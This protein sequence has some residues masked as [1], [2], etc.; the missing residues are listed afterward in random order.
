MP[1]V[2]QTSSPSTLPAASAPTPP[3]TLQEC[4][5]IGAPSDRLACYDRLAGRALPTP[6]PG[7]VPIATSQMAP[8][9]VLLAAANELSPSTSLLSQY[10]EL[11]AADKR[12]TFNLLGYRANYVAPLHKTSRINR[13]PQS[14]T[15]TP[16]LQPNYRTTEAKFQISLRT[17]VLQNV[18]DSGGDLWVA[19]TQQAM[20]QI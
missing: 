7:E 14:P 18:L 2:A 3:A 9:G 5:A 17:K 1:A 6:P 13:A 4:A 15:Q 16:V 10:W 20:W 11:D 8:K 19:F 12:G